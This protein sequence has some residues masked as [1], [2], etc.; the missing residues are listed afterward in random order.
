MWYIGVSGGKNDFKNL[1]ST[2]NFYFFF[3]S[4]FVLLIF[5]FRLF[6]FEKIVI[7]FIFNFLTLYF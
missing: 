1:P 6:C 4:H 3:E 5:F 7:C 2:I